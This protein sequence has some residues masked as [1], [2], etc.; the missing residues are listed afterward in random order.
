MNA[1][2]API[3]VQSGPLPRLVMQ[4]PPLQTSFAGNPN[5]RVRPPNPNDVTPTEPPTKLV[6]ITTETLILKH[7]PSR[8]GLLAL[9]KRKKVARNLETHEEH[10]TSADGG[11]AT[12]RHA[13][14]DTQASHNAA[15]PSIGQGN[16]ATVPRSR[17]L[18]RQS[19]TP[20]PRSKSLKQERTIRTPTTW[21]PPPLFQAYPQ[22]VKYASLRAPT[23]SA[24]AI[25]RSNGNKKTK[26]TGQIVMQSATPPNAVSADANVAKRKGYSGRK[27][28]YTLTE[29][30]PKEF[31]T[32]NLYV[33]VTSGYFLQYTGEGSFDRLPEKIMALSKDSAAFAS[34]AISGEHWVLQVSQ[35][36]DDNGIQSDKDQDSIMKKI[37]LLRDSKRSA[38]SFLLVLDSPEEMDSWL[39]AVRGEIES[40]GGKKYRPDATTCGST[41]DSPTKEFEK[42]SH[43]YSMG[44]DL[45]QNPG[46]RWE[47]APDVSFGNV[48][49]ENEGSKVVAGQSTSST[50]LRRSIASQISSDSPTV[51][52]STP[53][54]NQTYLDQLRG[55]HRLSYASTG[56]KTLSTSRGSS[57]G[58][59][60]RPAPAKLHFPL[61]EHASTLGEEVM[62]ISISTKFRRASV[63]NSSRTSI[64]PSSASGSTSRSA[65]RSPRPLSTRRS[66]PGQHTPPAALN[67]SVPTSSKRHSIVTRVPF[68]SM[69]QTSTSPVDDN[70]SSLVP[71]SPPTELSTEADDLVQSLPHSSS[72]YELSSPPLKNG[73]PLPRRLSSLQYSRGISPRHLPADQLLSPHPPPKTALPAVPR[74][75]VVADQKAIDVHLSQSRHLRRPMSMQVRSDPIKQIHHHLPESILEDKQNFDR[76]PNSLLDVTARPDFFDSPLLVHQSKLRNH[77]SMPEIDLPADFSLATRP[78]LPTLLIGSGLRSA[79]EN[80]APTH[81]PRPC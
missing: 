72:W 68:L 13:S 36:S 9:F 70:E 19:S 12:Y 63:Q 58:P 65:S 16:V 49:R 42:L 37:G 46:K 4:P 55:S 28:K 26:N 77:R 51:S 64:Y 60:P 33:L 40:M 41:E 75:L 47:P 50:V 5:Q 35:T 15:K 67:F 8:G 20:G 78:P 48:V 29:P 38:S 25:L 18:R 71:S 43:R 69:N 79:S 76:G 45:E 21:D 53:S 7:R 81:T 52:N 22:A 61:L 11:Q 24:D 80:S 66:S 1:I 6:S 17:T 74:H 56:A 44:R 14:R 3:A 31:W 2:A 59:S 73:R 30:I 62:P 23:V 27:P 10:G 54:V 32:D 34:D 57:P 39:R